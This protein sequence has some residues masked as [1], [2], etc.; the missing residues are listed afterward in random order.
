M[1]DE[2]TLQKKHL[3]LNFEGLDTYA[4]VYLN[5]S[6]ILKSNNAFRTFEVDVKSMLKASNELKI[7]FESTTTFH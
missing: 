7:L 5:D 2:E 4:S 3:E 1:V 6:L